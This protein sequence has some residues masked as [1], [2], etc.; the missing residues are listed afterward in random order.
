[1]DSNLHGQGG[2]TISGVVEDN[3]DWLTPWAPV[4]AESLSGYTGKHNINGMITNIW[5]Y[6]F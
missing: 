3:T 2:A 4:S 1:M 5:S 6:R